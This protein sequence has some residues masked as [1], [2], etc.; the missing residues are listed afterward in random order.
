MPA[1]LCGIRF[2]RTGVKRFRH[3]VVGDLT[4]A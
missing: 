2:Y 3:P 4:L 1:L